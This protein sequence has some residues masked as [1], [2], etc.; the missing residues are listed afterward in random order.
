MSSETSK[1]KRSKAAAGSNGH[2]S[3]DEIS[4]Q[5]QRL[6]AELEELGNTTQALVDS[7]GALLRDQL[8]RRPY[9]MLAT[10]AGVGY[11]L[12]GGLSLGLARAAVMMGGR[13]MLGNAVAR[14]VNSAT[15]PRGSRGATDP[16]E[17]EIR[18]G[19]RKDRRQPA[20]G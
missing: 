5:T 10:A 20:D 9:T 7:V 13:L 3:I 16:T 17:R 12:G 8:R 11:V 4:H 14:V 1:A 6:S 19:V 15:E 18:H 2:G